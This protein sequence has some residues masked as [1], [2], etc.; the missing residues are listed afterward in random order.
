MASS[1]KF[2]SIHLMI[3]RIFC[4]GIMLCGQIN[5]VLSLLCYFSK[6]TKIKK[7]TKVTKIT[8]L[9]T[10]CNSLYGS[11]LWDLEHSCVNDVCVTWIK[12]VSRVCDLPAG[13]HCYLL[14]IICD[15]IN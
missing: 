12:G 4:I 2:R 6:L 11:D 14:S 13:T 3:G 8:L 7:F 15:N 1:G 5:N 9:N 10:F